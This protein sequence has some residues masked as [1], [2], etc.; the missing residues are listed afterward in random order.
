MDTQPKVNFTIHHP[1]SK[2]KVQEAVMD[3]SRTVFSGIEVN[4]YD[5]VEIQ[6]YCPTDKNSI[7][8][9]ETY[10]T[11]E[12]VEIRH[13]ELPITIMNGS[14]SEH[15]LVPGHYKFEVLTK[16]GQYKSFYKVRSKDFSDESLINLR[17]YLENML[18]GLSYDLIKQKLGMAS[19]VP[20]L[21]PTLLQL[22]QFIN[23]YKEHIKSNLDL[24][25]KDPIT[26][27]I[28]EYHVTSH[29]KKLD[30][31]SFRW[32]ALKGE[33]RNS[34]S[35]SPRLFYEKHA[36]LTFNNIENQWV[37]FIINFFLQSLRKLEVSFQKEISQ[38]TMKQESMQIQLFENRNRIEIVK[39][40]NTFG[41]Q[42]SLESLKRKEKRILVRM[43]ELNKETYSYSE[44]KQ[45]LRKLTHFFTEYEKTKWVLSLPSNKPKK[46]TQRMLKDYRYR[47]I[48]NLYK[49][50]A[51]LETRNIESNLP[52]I[53]F[54]RTWQ[55][56]EYYNV[57]LVINTLKENG[58][59]WVDGW[60]ASKDSPHLH[61]GT[62]P[63]G[64]IMRF[65]KDDSDHY[66][67]LAYDNEIESSIIDQSYSRYFNNAGR[68]PDILLTIYR[69]DG[70]LFSNKAGLIIESKCRR[71]RYLINQ[72]IDP[73]VKQ[74]LRDFKN[75]E[76][77]D[78]SAYRIGGDPVKTPIQ[79]VIVL[80]P[81]Q[82]GISPVKADHVYGEGMLY[83][84]VEPND[85]K[86]NETSFGY[87]NLKSKIDNFISQVD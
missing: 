8:K 48:Y 66:I 27:L 24:I 58:Y 1:F 77:F 79:K 22:F 67:E 59:K 28:G 26:D 41:F 25:S 78:S 63:A 40:G 46:I 37:K 36:K 53:Q 35:T 14:N 32:Q 57:G 7:L 5:K 68:R 84:Q 4:E 71:H 3:A 60:L 42:K 18:K 72:N 55:L 62:L 29:P 31:K 47:K 54:R 23:K 81:K 51:R 44:Q 85:P 19:P 43:E 52:G 56:F 12:E 65:E 73:D 49:E 87:E 2:P 17:S 34:L 69:K 70:T 83:I 64:T 80:Y 30:S 10:E 16:N 76:Y 61:I 6:F 74:Q 33:Q 39:N 21:N 13:S 15:M 11:N 50:L 20:D 9:I 38:V 82:A 86:S 45:F 75:L